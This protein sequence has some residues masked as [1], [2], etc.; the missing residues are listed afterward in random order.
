M[1]THL[2]RP[3][4]ARLRSLRPERHFGG[5]RGVTIWT[6]SRTLNGRHVEIDITHDAVTRT[7]VLRV[8]P[9]GGATTAREVTLHHLTRGD[10]GRLVYRAPYRN[11][12]GRVVPAPAPALPV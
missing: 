12:A 11:P 8:Y 6:Y 3:A 4:P 7:T 9:W 1:T 2:Q 5:S 10:V